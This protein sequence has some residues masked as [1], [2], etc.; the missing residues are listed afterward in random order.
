[1]DNKLTIALGAVG[2]AVM[3]AAT[4]SP[5]DAVSNIS[6]WLEYL[7]IDQLPTLLE[8][9]GI[10]K[11]ATV[12]GGMLFASSVSI[13]AMRTLNQK[14]DII[15][16]VPA[17]TTSHNAANEREPSE[18]E[19]QAL[20]ELTIFALD[21][22]LPTI[23]ELATLQ[24][25]LLRTQQG[26]MV[27]G[28]FAIRAIFHK[29]PNVQIMYGAYSKIS[30]LGGSPAPQ[31]SLSDMENFVHSIEQNYRF[32][33]SQLYQITVSLGIDHRKEHEFTPSWQSWREK[34]GAMSA[35]YDVIRRSKKFN[36][37]YRPGLPNRFNE[38]VA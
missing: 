5:K 32:F 12:I 23:D 24:K 33:T 37:L 17:Q 8:D 16:L 19:E 31:Y 35:A 21:H 38:G 13:I 18:R 36:K 22:V 1:M 7:G 4:I 28:D 10:D 29:H 6:G 2:A 9:P 14:P 15:E 26:S 11:W 34:H 3:T 27:V 25:A 30:E 20:E